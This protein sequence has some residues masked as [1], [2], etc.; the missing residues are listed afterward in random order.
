MVP[1][2]LDSYQSVRYPFFLIALCIAVRLNHGRKKDIPYKEGKM[3]NIGAHVG[4]TVLWDR[5]SKVVGAGVHMCYYLAA[6]PFH[7]MAVLSGTHVVRVLFVWVA[8]P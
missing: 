2:L 7:V 8:T 1:C 5:V 4:Y 6:P 3:K